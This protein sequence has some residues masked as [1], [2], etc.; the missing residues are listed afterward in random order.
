MSF[1]L[2]QDATT[3]DVG[4]CGALVLKYLEHLSRPV[5]AQVCN[6]T[7]PDVWCTFW[8]TVGSDR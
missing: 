5:A 2:V 6:H 4:V 8:P 7:R 1:D 3:M